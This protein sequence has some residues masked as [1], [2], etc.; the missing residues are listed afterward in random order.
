MLDPL[1]GTR[2]YAVR[3]QVVGVNAAI[4][5]DGDS[6]AAAVADPFADEVFWT[7]GTRASV[8]RA[9]CDA[10]LVPDASSRLVELNADPPFPDGAS[11][12]AVLLAADPAFIDRFRPRVVSTSLALAWVATG[13]RAGYIS[14]GE[15]CDSVHFAA[16]I[17]VCEA[18]GCV[19]S[20]LWGKPLGSGPVG[21]LAA[22]DSA[23]H[24]ALLHLVRKHL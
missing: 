8:R 4:C 9:G 22:A 16:G 12:R 11:F 6:L 17:A 18:A 21:L 1:C 14:H 23:T 10:A 19:L 5:E 13:Q 7:D 20:D 3:M 24:S 15:L 2:N